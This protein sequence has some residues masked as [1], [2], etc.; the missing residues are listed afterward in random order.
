MPELYGTIG[1]ELIILCRVFDSNCYQE[2]SRKYLQK[3][4]KYSL[5]CPS[6]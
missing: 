5:K 1:Y 3:C 6:G 4:R 2:V